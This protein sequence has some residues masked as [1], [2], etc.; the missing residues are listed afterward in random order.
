MKRDAS[1][2]CRRTRVARLVEQ[3]IVNGAGDAA[4]PD[5]GGRSSEK[6]GGPT[7]SSRRLFCTDPWHVPGK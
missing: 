6:V 2:V 3:L 4:S 5:G 7:S 1:D